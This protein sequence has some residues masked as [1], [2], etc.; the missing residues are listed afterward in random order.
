MKKYFIL[1]LIS[2]VAL[3][4]DAYAEKEKWKKGE[5]G[6]C[7]VEYKGSPNR[8]FY[9]GDQELGCAD[10]KDRKKASYTY[11][12]N[13]YLGI[14]DADKK[15]YKNTHWA[16]CENNGWKWTQI[17]GVS[18]YSGGGNLTK[19]TKTGTATVE[20]ETGG[21]CTYNITIGICGDEDHSLRDSCREADGCTNGLILR[22]GTCINACISG[23]GYESMTSN[24][25]MECPT[26]SKGGVYPTTGAD[27]SK[28]GLCVQCADAEIFNYQTGECKA[29]TSVKNQYNKT[30]FKKCWRC[31]TMDDFKTCINNA[32]TTGIPDSCKE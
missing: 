12:N 9:C 23:Q 2:I 3:T 10:K 24:A 27:A 22:N 28:A 20:L 18:G 11:Y 8:F 30:V 32:S 21:T 14:S 31:E 15:G 19:Y 1:F 5:S 26:T 7:F 4:P 25:C 17:D 6:R 16:C 13:T 29:K